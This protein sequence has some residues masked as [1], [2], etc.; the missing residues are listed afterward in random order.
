MG[1]IAQNEFGGKMQ[2]KFWRENEK[3]IL[4]GK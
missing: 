1:G 3:D 2:K 4:A